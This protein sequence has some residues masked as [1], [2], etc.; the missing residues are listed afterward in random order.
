MT[1]DMTDEEFSYF[2]K[3]DQDMRDENNATR[4]LIDRLIL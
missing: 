4:I 3:K 2:A 1:N